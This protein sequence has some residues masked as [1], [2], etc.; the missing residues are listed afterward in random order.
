MAQLTTILLGYV[1]HRCFVITALVGIIAAP[2]AHAD[3]PSIARL[4]NEQLLEAIRNDTARPTVHARNLWHVS[5]AMYDAWAVF[6]PTSRT[7][8]EP[9]P[10]VT[11]EGDPAGVAAARHEAI[12]YAAYRVLRHRFVDGPGGTGPGR[13]LTAFQLDNQMNALGYD[14]NVTT[15]AGD[16][17]AALGNRIAQRV[18]DFGLGDSANESNDYAE[19]T[20]YAPVNPPLTFDE[21]GTTMNDP[22]RWQPLRFV[23]ERR[24]QFGT[25]VEETVQSFLSPYWGDVTPFALRPE[26]RSENGVYLDQGAPP[27]LG[28]SGDGDF[29][30]AVNLIIRYSSELDPADTR[31]VDISP[32]SMGNRPLGTYENVGHA[33]NPVTGQPYEPHMVRHADW[34]RIIAEFWADGPDSEAPPGHWNVIANDVA[35]RMDALGMDKRLGGTGPA[36]D[37]LEWDVKTYFALN[38]AVHDAAV[39][40][41]NHKGLYDYARPI[42]MIRYMGQRGQSSDPGLTVEVNGETLS[43]YDPEGLTLEPGLV[44]VITPQTTAPGERHEHLA[45]H[46]GKIA[47]R[48]WTGAPDGAHHGPDDV[49]GV[50]WILAERWMPYQQDTFVTPPFAGYVSGHSTFSRAAAEVLAAITGSAYFPG[51]LFEHAF[52]AGEGLEFEYGPSEDLILQWAT[53]FDAADEAALSR[54]YGGIHVPADDLPGRRIGSIVGPQAWDLAMQYYT[55]VI[56]E[57]GTMAILWMLAPVIRRRRTKATIT[58]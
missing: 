49:G 29:R 32:A 28:G 21:L 48:S 53:Y 43:T 50:G 39:A 51:G 18:I 13:F 31:V 6:D 46:E 17:P 15:T 7:Y 38:G 27:M 55:G 35:D 23:R 24:D 3:D 8:L 56:P 45:G 9:D 57:P 2:M 34:A 40:A 54:L 12:S 30:D 16:S 19:P 1:R 11:P 26:Q 20:G 52:P 22:N 58:A 25:V 14:P 47:I 44:E 41:W 37:D 5:V 42:S 36:V 33:V 10:L 4:W